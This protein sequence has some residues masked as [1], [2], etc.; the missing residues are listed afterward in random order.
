MWLGRCMVGV[1]WSGMMLL[2]MVMIAAIRCLSPTR[3]SAIRQTDGSAEPTKRASA[4]THLT[5]AAYCF[6]G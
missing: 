3:A 2:A 5:A 1:S 6:D 4:A